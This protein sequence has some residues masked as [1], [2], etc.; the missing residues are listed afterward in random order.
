MPN[1]VVHIAH[2][3]LHYAGTAVLCDLNWR[4][5]PGEHWLIAGKSGSGKS[6]LAKAIVKQEKASGEVIFQFDPNSPMPA[7][8]YYVS[9]W[10][11]FTNLEGD[12]NFYY[13]QR[14]NKQ[15]Q[16]DTLTVYADLV[17][18]GQKQQLDLQDAE[19][20]LKAL[21]FENCRATQLIEL[22]SGEHK[23]LQ[24]VQA[25]WLRPQLLILDEPYTG[26]DRRS[27]TNLNLILDEIAHAGTQLILITNDSDIPTSINRFAQ[28]EQGRLQSVTDLS[29]I[30]QD[31]ERRQKPLPYFLQQ[32][33]YVDTDTMIE[34][35][36]VSV[37][38]GEK[39]VLKNVSWRVHAGEKWLLQGPNGS[40]KS[41]LLSL[42]NG[43]HPQAYA[44]DIFLFGKKR[45]TGESIW[46]IKAK[47]GIIS[48][49]LH[50]YFDKNATVWHT[51]ASGFYDSIGWFVQVKYEEKKQ[52]EQVLDFFDLLEDKDKLLHTLPLG[53][54]RLALLARTIVK[55]PQLLILD[56]PCQGLDKSQTAHFNAVL[57]ELSGYGK[58]LIYVGHY[59]SQLPSCLD[60][61]LVLEDGKVI[62]RT[63]SPESSIV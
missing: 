22:S 49:E 26:L 61:R 29:K 63:C 57:D 5:Y 35:R 13:Q 30:A 40:G 14:Y 44:N 45:G 2:L 17:H 52:M 15:Q 27:R 54:Q 12:R 6:S 50:W 55:N 4:I 48:P 37:R 36:D 58:T 19:P 31:E 21:G 39:E 18:F 62:F 10:Y 3:D 20:I 16:N 8:A 42:L 24:L 46:D 34:L 41:T 59:E 9:N 47:I 56:E 23:K 32:A 51:V 1:P 33:P 43:D 53:K 11:Q 28:I 38:Y 7:K 60:N 25:L